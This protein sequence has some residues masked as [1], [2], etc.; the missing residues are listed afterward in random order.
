MNNKIRGFTLIEILIALAI[1]S[2][3]L[4]AIL[5]SSSQNIK[6]TYYLQQKNMALWIANDALNEVRAGLLKL[7]LAPDVEEGHVEMFG[8][9]WFWSGNL[10]TTPNPHIFEIHMNIFSIKEGPAIYT[11][12]GYLYAQS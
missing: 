7:P 10:T 6:D 12:L 2:I 1:L 11:Q 8:R 5:K 9:S 3:A 4:T